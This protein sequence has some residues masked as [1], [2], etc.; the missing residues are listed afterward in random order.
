MGYRLSTGGF[1][2][3]LCGDANC[4]VFTTAYTS[5]SSLT[6]T[7][8]SQYVD[9]PNT[10]NTY[11]FTVDT[12]GHF[13]VFSGSYQS[14]GSTHTNPS[15]SPALPAGTIY[16]ASMTWDGTSYV[17]V[18]GIGSSST[19]EIVHIYKGT[20]PAGPFSGAGLTSTNL[21]AGV[22]APWIMFDSGKYYMFFSDNTTGTARTLIAS[23]T[24]LNTWTTSSKPVMPSSSVLGVSNVTAVEVSGYAYL[25]YVYSDS[26]GSVLSTAAYNGTL[27]QYLSQFTFP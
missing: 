4:S 5:P 22:Y 14:I 2:I 10:S 9:T 15:F 25:S 23:S 12:S 17:L 7:Y 21:P 27:H 16:D 8:L 24:D 18:L 20:S 19:T 6:N 11:V 26:S 13:E 3:L 1:T